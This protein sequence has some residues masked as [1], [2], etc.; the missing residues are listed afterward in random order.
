MLP[1]I[2]LGSARNC[3]KAAT[4][5][6]PLDA[7]KEGRPHFH[8]L[9]SFGVGTLC[10]FFLHLLPP[11]GCPFL[12]CMPVLPLVLMVAGRLL[13]AVAVL[14]PACVTGAWGSWQNEESGISVGT[15]YSVRQASGED[16]EPQH[17]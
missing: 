11:C 9:Q 15:V 12:F 13:F 4:I 16:M 7:R 14:G 17:E 5:S 6:D 8:F 1:I 2:V 3:F 10:F